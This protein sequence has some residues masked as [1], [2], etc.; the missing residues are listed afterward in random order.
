MS[1]SD[2]KHLTQQGHPF[3]SLLLRTLLAAVS[4]GTVAAG[5]LTLSVFGLVVL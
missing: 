1:G 4:V 2:M 3:S 5:L